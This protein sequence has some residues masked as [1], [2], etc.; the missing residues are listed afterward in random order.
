M[1]RR[2]RLSEKPASPHRLPLP[3]DKTT[4]L[5]VL[6]MASN[7]VM[8]DMYTKTLYELE[9]AN[10]EINSLTRLPRDVDKGGWRKVA[11]LKRHYG[12][13]SDIP[14][15]RVFKRPPNIITLFAIFL[16]VV[17]VMAYGQYSGQ[18]GAWYQGLNLGAPYLVAGM[19]FLFA[20]ILLAR[21]R[22]RRSPS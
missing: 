6:S 22:R 21:R 19:I 3:E 20:I 12:K 9:T 2:R 11:A 1:E 16:G 14:D 8:L 7:F 17:V 18:L 10:Q 4:K 13:I 15:E 5:F